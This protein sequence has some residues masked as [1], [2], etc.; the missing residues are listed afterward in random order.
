MATISPLAPDRF[1][2]LP[3][4]AGVRLAAIEAGLRYQARADLMLAELVPGTTAAGVFTRSRCPSAPV[5][6]CK[7]ILPAGTARAVVC[8]AGNANAFTGRAGETAA[9]SDGPRRWLRSL[10]CA[11]RRRSSWPRPA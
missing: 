7:R 4:V 11:G 8:N 3:T 2:D 9:R 6:W 10:G 1:P 5:D